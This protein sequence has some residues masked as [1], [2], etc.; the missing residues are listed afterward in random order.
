MTVK[1]EIQQALRS[2]R[3]TAKP[4]EVRGYTVTS[5]LTK[6]RLGVT[7]HFYAQPVSGGAKFGGWSSAAT[8]TDVLS[9]II[10]KGN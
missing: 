5:A 1:Q 3:L 2:V 9:R 4:V 6:H 8:A 7:L 10:Q